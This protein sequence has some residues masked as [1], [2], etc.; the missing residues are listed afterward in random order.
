MKHHII[1]QIVE[2]VFEKAKKNCP[3]DAHTTL[4]YHI[5]ERSKPRISYRTAARA[6][7]KY[8]DEDEMDWSPNRE[9]IENF[10]KYL[11]YEDY[12]DYREKKRQLI[13]N[14]SIYETPPKI[15]TPLPDPNKE[16]EGDEKRKWILRVTIILS[17]MIV[18]FVYVY[19]NKSNIKNENEQ[20]LAECMAW[21]KDHY[22]KT[23]CNLQLHP[24]YGTKVEPYDASRS[25]IEKIEVDA[26]TDFFS[27]VTG[28]P[29]VWYYKTQKGTL[30]YFN[31]PGLH[32][33]NKET[34]K[35]ITQGMIEKYV[36]IHI[37]K[38]DSF[39]S[40]DPTN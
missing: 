9:S 15:N 4:S 3:S 36:P 1:K 32:P 26:S 23:N 18:L 2:E 21:A 8:I 16:E 34:L 6:Y 7:K 38:P 17:S 20:P 33:V 30:E 39:I 27:E 37:T 28:Q 25:T 5:E 11:D 12:S 35:K 10:C 40:S 31:S 24:D 22:E 29:L 14:D 13:E 19:I